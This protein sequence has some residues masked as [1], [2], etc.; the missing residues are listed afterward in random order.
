MTSS[1]D[2]IIEQIEK[3]NDEGLDLSEVLESEHAD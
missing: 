1:T 2:D 3:G